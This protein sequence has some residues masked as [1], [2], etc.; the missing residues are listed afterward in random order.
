MKNLLVATDLSARSDRAVQRAALLAKRFGCEWTLLHVIDDD[1]PSRLVE[2]QRADAVELLES[3]VEGLALIA[4][5][6]PRVLVE[7]GAVEKTINEIAIGTGS[8]L[9]VLGMPRRGLLREI[10]LGTS[11]ERIIRSSRLPVLRVAGGGDDEYRT[12]MLAADMSGSCAN[13]IQTARELG[14]LEGCTLHAV[15]VFEAFAKGEI[16]MSAAEASIV[17]TA[18]REA[19]LQTEAELSTFLG[20]QHLDLPPAQV[21]IEE[22][23]SVVQLKRAVERLD[24]DLLVI[25]THGRTGLKKM[26]IGSVAETL[27]GE[28]ERDIL[29]VPLPART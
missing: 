10:F 7:P 13:A 23:F 27:L 11:A 9:L 3:R 1:Q 22:G 25:G 4:G 12:A 28:V 20:E 16:L 19:R 29:C 15:H 26:L 5:Q 14:L 24:P 18:T 21:H 17:S 6:R 8:E 2:R